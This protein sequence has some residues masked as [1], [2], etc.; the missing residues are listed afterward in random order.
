[1]GNKLRFVNHSKKNKNA[2]A[3]IFFSEGSHK[4]GLFSIKDIKKYE[5]ILFDYDGRDELIERFPWINDHKIDNNN[6]TKKISFNK[7]GFILDKYKDKNNRKDVLLNDSEIINKKKI[8][9]LRNKRKKTPEKNSH[10]KI[11]E[12]IE[13]H[14]TSSEEIDEISMNRNKIN[15]SKR[16]KAKKLL[17]IDLNKVYQLYFW[18]YNFK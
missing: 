2:E 3:K 18:I 9:F 14:N 1:M 7:N 15:T 13:L 4:V 16:M 11:N 10:K 17:F 8:E 6:I 12:V 5:E